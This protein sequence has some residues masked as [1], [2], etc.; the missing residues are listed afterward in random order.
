MERRPPSSGP[1]AEWRIGGWARRFL[2]AGAASFV[3]AY[4]SVYDTPAYDFS[5]AFYGG[6]LSGKPIGQAVQEARAAIKPAGDRTWLA[7]VVYADPL[8]AL[9]SP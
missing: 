2:E 6:V 4:W 5:K 8:A 7:Y 3:G 1:R 9:Q